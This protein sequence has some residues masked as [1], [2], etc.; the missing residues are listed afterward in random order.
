M[1]EKPMAPAQSAPP[2]SA[3]LITPTDSSAPSVSSGE[4]RAAEGEQTGR[5]PSSGRHRLWL[6]ITWFIEVDDQGYLLSQS[7]E[8]ALGYV[9]QCRSQNGQHSALKLPR[10]RGDS[11]IENAEYCQVLERE[12]KEAVKVDG[13]ESKHG[14]VRLTH[15]DSRLLCQIPNLEDAKHTKEQHGYIILVRFEKDRPIRII[16]IKKEGDILA[17]IPKNDSLRKQI[18]QEIRSEDWQN[19]VVGPLDSHSDIE[20]RKPIAFDC[21]HQK[22]KETSGPSREAV[23]GPL[24]AH[25]GTP[26]APVFWYAWLPSIL[27]E[28]AQGTLQGALNTKEHKEWTPVD[29]YDLLESV[30]AGLQTLHQLG[31]IHGDVRPANIMA[32]GRLS[33][34]RSYVLGD[35]GSFTVDLPMGA[36]GS[37]PPTGFSTPPNIARHRASSFYARERR[38]GVEREDAEVAVITRIVKPTSSLP[39]TD[40][41]LASTPQKAEPSTSLLITLLSKREVPPLDN[42]EA[43]TSHRVESE[44]TE[45]DLIASE[46]KTCSDSWSLWSGDQVRIR[47]LVFQVRAYRED[48]ATGKIYIACQPTFRRVMNERIVVDSTDNLFDFQRIENI[49]IIDIPRWVEVRQASVASDLFGVGSVALYVIYS[50]AQ[51]TQNPQGAT[52]NC[53]AKIA[54]IIA[55]LENE[56]NFKNL[57]PDLRRICST[58]ESAFDTFNSSISPNSDPSPP[59]IATAICHKIQSILRSGQSSNIVSKEGIISGSAKKTKNPRSSQDAKSLEDFQSDYHA[60]ITSLIYLVPEFK[61]VLSYYKS[62]AHFL[63]FVEF[64]LCCIH[65]RSHLGSQSNNDVMPFC[66]NRFEKP[67]QPEQPNTTTAVQLALLRLK[68]LRDN[69]FPNT[70]FFSSFEEIMAPPQ[71]TDNSIESDYALR[72]KND[73]FQKKCSKLETKQVDLQNQLGEAIK[74]RDARQQ[75]IVQMQSQIAKLQT[76]KSALEKISVL[77]QTNCSALKLKMN[78][79]EAEKIKIVAER[80][81]VTAEKT[82]LK[83][84]LSDEQSNNAVLEKKLASRDSTQKDID[85]KLRTF[86]TDMREVQAQFVEKSSIFQ[87]KM[88]ALSSE[89]KSR[90]DDLVANLEKAI[91]SPKDYG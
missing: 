14:I 68:R 69:Y 46:G 83:R 5:R 65:R 45:A 50:R 28:W 11:Q 57:W 77:D 22:K 34:P 60:V 80:D 4:G 52:S 90:A 7:A 61:T 62:Y 91:I 17:I 48:T 24:M 76:E 15:P 31:M 89:K 54:G 79:L 86:I 67:N 37:V 12:A 6:N 18:A 25:L 78:A 58:I 64:I 2:P 8:G 36:A 81:S 39:E 74:E 63:F 70:L 85:Q 42:T 40:K 23:A 43:W 66:R 47:D 33:S 41:A 27:F 44:K 29:I 26:G 72:K 38:A 9:I 55:K 59:E 35:Y 13:A 21:N 20:A 75:F 32:C 73:E 10:L 87:P 16:K 82:N 3:V 53:E 88:Y 1:L 19:C 51:L 84:A 30:L 71:V 49:A 56:E